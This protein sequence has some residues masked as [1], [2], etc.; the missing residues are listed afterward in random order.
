MKD[1]G[2]LYIV[3]T[4]IGNMGDISSRAI[5]TL[6]T[7]NK[8]YAEDTRVGI[9]LMKSLGIEKIIESYHAHSHRSIYDQILKDLIDGANLALI[10]DAGTP[11]ISDPGNEL[12]NY[13]LDREPLLQIRSI[14]GPSSITSA[15]S[16]SGFKAN[17]F[18]FLG[19]L[20]KKKQKA[21]FEK[22]SDSE[23]TAIYFDSPHRVLGN[24]RKL[25]DYVGSN[26]RVFVARELT[27]IHETHYRGA[28]EEVIKSLESEDYLKGEIVCIIEGK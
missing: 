6:S 4:P 22:I 19:F 16:I 12:I 9:K 17:T 25:L 18:N 24:L 1:F 15:L 14:P 26:R 11:G 3:A 20:P 27:K 23:D 2:I 8:I 13:L 28:I 7:V 10:S 21:I 5:E